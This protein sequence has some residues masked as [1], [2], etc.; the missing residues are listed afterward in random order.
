VTV[1]RKAAEDGTVDLRERAG[2]ED[3]AVTVT[4]LVSAVREK[5]S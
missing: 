4:E 1:G 5:L 3:V 2:G